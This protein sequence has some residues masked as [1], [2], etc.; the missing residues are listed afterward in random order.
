M[1]NDYI[2]G[3]VTPLIFQPFR[4]KIRARG[5]FFFPFIDLHMEHKRLEC[6]PPC[7]HIFQLFSCLVTVAVY[8]GAEL[9]VSGK[10][11]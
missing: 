8:V 10:V 4:I 9:N 6:T 5:S 1:G 3:D 11:S 2:N 7:A